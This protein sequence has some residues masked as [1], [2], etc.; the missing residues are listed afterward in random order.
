MLIAKNFMP[1][2]WWRA[3]A[4]FTVVK[5]PAVR[6]ERAAVG[7]RHLD[8]P[9]C[10]GQVIRESQAAI[11][12]RMEDLAMGEV[13]WTMLL[14]RLSLAGVCALGAALL[15]G[16][17]TD[18]AAPRAVHASPGSPGLDIKV[19]SIGIA[20]DLSYPTTSVYVQ[21]NAGSQNVVVYETGTT[22]SIVSS[23]VDLTKN[24]PYTIFVLGEPGHVALV[25]HAESTSDSDGL[26]S[27][28][29]KVRAVNGAFTAGPV[30]VYVTVP[31]IPLT[32][33]IKPA[34][35]ALTFGAV[36]AYTAFT[37]GQFE[38]RVTPQGTQTPVLI[39]TNITV[40]AA[41]DYSVLVVDPTSPGGPITS[42]L[43]ADPTLPTSF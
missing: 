42:L 41:L 20:Q 28:Q 5:L 3:A 37:A 4:E 18:H 38:V 34:F 12:I 16:C 21:V 14:R 25:S 1:A 36:S 40:G 6:L 43:L 29:A 19:G 11:L 27:N 24:T 8:P 10:G 23:M 39:D 32:P 15:G 26:S 31:K 22:T 2:G 30:D 7:Q 33:S 13:S 35:P 17:G 9:I